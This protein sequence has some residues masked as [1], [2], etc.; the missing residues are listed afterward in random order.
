MKRGQSWDGDRIF[1]HSGVKKIPY[2]GDYNPEQWP[3]EVWEEDMRLFKLAGIDCVTLN[4][5]SWAS[6]Q[7]AEDTYCFDKLDRIMEFV[8]KNGLFVILATSTAAHPAWMAR[9][10]PQVL[11]TEFS[12]L[13]R[14]FGGRHNSCPNSPVYRKYSR[15]LAGKLAERYGHFDN[16]IGWH[17]NNEY[18]G[19]CYCENC[20]RAFRQWLKEKYGTLE[21][22]NQAWNTSFWGHT[23]Y[24]WEEIVVPNLQSEHFAEERTTFQGISLDY[25]RFSSD[26]MLENYRGERE[27]I[28]RV[29]GD[30]PV[31][32]NLM[33]FY[34]P[35]D[36][37]KWAEYMDFVSWDN[38][39]DNDATASAV[40]MNH[41]LMRGLKGGRPFAL[42]EQTPSVTNWLSYNALKR[43]G[44]M[45]LLSWQAVAH[46]A[47]TVL[48]FQMR[49]SV[50]ACE[51]YHGAVI[52]HVGNENTRVFR[53]VQA[54][55]KELKEVGGRTLGGRTP[56]RAAILVDW[57]NWWA[58]EYSAGPSC[59]LKYLDEVE[60][61][62]TA[63]HARNISVDF[64]SVKDSLESYR[65]LVAPVLYMVKEGYE[66]VL[67]EFVKRGG[68][69]VTTFFSGIVEEHDLVVTGGYPGHLR[70]LMGIWVE[71]SDALPEGCQNGFVWKGKHYPAE[72]LCDIMHLEGA[73]CEARYETDFYAGSPVLSRNSFG[74]G[75]AWYVAARSSREF[76]EDLVKQL[77]KDGGVEETWTQIPGVEVCERI[78]EQGRFFFFLNHGDKEAE[79]SLKEDGLWVQEGRRCHK[80]ETLSLKGKDVIL[81]QVEDTVS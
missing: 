47:D 43:P 3:E 71:E 78:N 61:Y 57:D 59:D 44:V 16:L 24:D 17:V 20:E 21:R 30:I 66:K 36:Y 76:Y 58:L 11:R 54:L 1:N 9:K 12:G 2:G 69:F 4:V 6:L 75:A 70:E 79:I 32:T 62:Y 80:G 65:I 39:P 45:R 23:F 40:A 10:Y 56:A 15:K 77:I 55:G 28:R 68:I 25:Q 63:F 35:L 72:L 19:V 34:K 31:T 60:R 49:R 51:K 14:K 42:M 50:G 48:F 7:P 26:S 64:I 41:D 5:F 74:K 22:L 81:Y 33:G 52:D 13:R 73:E 18:G 46:G 8:R 38:Y 37:Q 67:E 27:S 29:T 53:E